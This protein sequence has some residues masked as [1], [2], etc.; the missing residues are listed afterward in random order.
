[1]KCFLEDC[2][3]NYVTHI[4]RASIFC[5]HHFGGWFGGRLHTKAFK[6]K[7]SK[8]LDNSYLHEWVL[9]RVWTDNFF[10]SIKLQNKVLFIEIL[11]KLCIHN[12]N[13][14]IDIVIESIQ[15]LDLKYFFG[16][17]FLRFFLFLCFE[18]SP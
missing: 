11:S 8:I 2:V 6:F 16:C 14:A 4:S 5:G 1:M 9:K 18:F 13:K 7:E 10:V 12:R 3:N 15:F 17:T